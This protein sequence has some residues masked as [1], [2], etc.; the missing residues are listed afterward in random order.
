MVEPLK[1]DWWLIV[2]IYMCVCNND[3]LKQP[4]IGNVLKCKAGFNLKF[5]TVQ[6]Y[7]VFLSGKF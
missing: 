1:E 7:Y 2:Y 3:R 4:F 6:C 5:E